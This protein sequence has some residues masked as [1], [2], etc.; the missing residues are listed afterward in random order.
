MKR[1][2]SI[3]M[4]VIVVGEGTFINSSSVI[5]VSTESQVNQELTMSEC[6]IGFLEESATVGKGIRC[7]H[8]LGMG[9]I[10]QLIQNISNSKELTTILTSPDSSDLGNVSGK[11]FVGEVSAYTIELILGRE[12]LTVKQRKLDDSFALGSDTNNY[13]YRQGMIVS[14]GGK[15]IGS[16]DLNLIEAC[17]SEWWDANKSRTIDELR[18]DWK[19][20]KRP[21]SQTEFHWK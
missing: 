14:N 12:V 1:Y 8:D 11:M 10:P 5:G 9:A 7:L 4:F 13:V 21:I 17:Y 2:L 18:T 19:N 15:R 20:G 3:F 6:E 16:A